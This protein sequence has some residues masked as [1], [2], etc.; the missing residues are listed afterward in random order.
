MSDQYKVSGVMI[1]EASI[2]SLLYG[3]HYSKH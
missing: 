2:E 3:G 1:T